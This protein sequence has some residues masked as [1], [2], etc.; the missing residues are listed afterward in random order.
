MSTNP[1]ESGPRGGGGAMTPLWSPH[2]GVAFRRIDGEFV[3]LHLETGHYYGLDGAGASIWE[4]LG[5]PRTGAE[6]AAKLGEEF[7]AGPERIEADVAAFLALMESRGLVRRV[8]PGGPEGG[9]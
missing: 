3:L 4:G 1:S 7:D 9:T 8:R 5:E 2:P 6:L